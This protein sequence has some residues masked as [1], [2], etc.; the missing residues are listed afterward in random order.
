MVVQLCS[1]GTWILFVYQSFH[2]L[3]RHFEYISFEDR[4]KLG[5]A[6]FWQVIISSAVGMALLK[7][8]IGLNLLRL[9]P[10]RW[11]VWCLWISIGKQ[12]KSIP[13]AKRPVDN[14][15]HSVC[16]RIQLHGRHDVFPP[17]QT[18]AGAL[19]LYHQ[20]RQMLFSRPLHHIRPHQHWCVDLNSMVASQT[21]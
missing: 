2:G 20:G 13:P 5:Q 14:M 7:I 19:G 18:H 4:I 10:S 11:Y 12:F 3:G 21:D 17:L 16:F 15:V 1:I 6:N 8:S 9:S